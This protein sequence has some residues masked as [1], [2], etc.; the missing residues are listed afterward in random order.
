[1]A[2]VG[3]QLLVWEWK[4][5]IGNSYALAMLLVPA[6]WE[7]KIVVSAVQAFKP[8]QSSSCIV[9]VWTVVHHGVHSADAS[10]QGTF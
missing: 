10:F 3:R 2:Q 9:Q 6:G 5:S 8:A 7:G 4:V 1:M